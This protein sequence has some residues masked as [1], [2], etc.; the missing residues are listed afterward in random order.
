MFGIFREYI[1]LSMRKNLCSLIFL[2]VVNYAEAQ[3][4]FE[5]VSPE[6]TPHIG[7][8]MGKSGSLFLL[9]AVGS[10]DSVKTCISKMDEDGNF[11]WSKTYY[12]TSGIL[13]AWKILPASDFGFFLTGCYQKSGNSDYFILK[14]D[15]NGSVIWSWS[16]DHSQTENSLSATLLPGGGIMLAGASMDSVSHLGDYNSLLKTD[17]LGNVLFFKKYYTSGYQYSGGNVFLLD[18]STCLMLCSYQQNFSGVWKTHLL[19]ID[20]SGSILLTSSLEN[21]TQNVDIG[22]ALALPNGELCLIGQI[23]NLPLF[24]RLNSSG[25]IQWSKVLTNFDN[26]TIYDIVNTHNNQYIAIG[27][28][29]DTANA[30]S[31]R[32]LLQLDSAGNN[33]RMHSFPRDTYATIA[34]IAAEGEDNGLY[35]GGLLIPFSNF[36]LQKT[37]SIGMASCGTTPL[38][39][40]D[41]SISLVQNSPVYFDSTFT[42]AQNNLFVLDSAGISFTDFCQT[43]NITKYSSIDEALILSPNP[44]S[45]KLTITNI[46]SPVQEIYLYNLLGEKMPVN[47]D[48]RLLTVDCSLL[49]PGIYILQAIGDGK[50]LCGKV[51]ME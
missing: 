17:S 50:V 48:Y 35:M 44:V 34:G 45:G 11:Y 1:F 12:P 51:I 42:V 38:S 49:L 20:L 15:S 9:S 46:Q 32:F 29:P 28:C 24:A 36:I 7:M 10:P 16:Y 39:Y 25:I 43:L 13:E 6:V 31:I 22:K 26:T 30:H 2:F 27:I 5:K 47:I 33:I 23:E 14:A 8:A 41:S 40:Y 3:S 18:D 19:K 37:D 21:S 4:T